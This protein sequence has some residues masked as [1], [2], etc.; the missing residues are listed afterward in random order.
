MFL[1]YLFFV[2]PNHVFGPSIVFE[3]ITDFKLCI[4]TC[5]TMQKLTSFQLQ[6]SMYPL[7]L[8]A[9]VN[10]VCSTLAA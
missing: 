6:S 8:C 1:F 4:N 2:P 10:T 7:S 3:V 5:N 9:V